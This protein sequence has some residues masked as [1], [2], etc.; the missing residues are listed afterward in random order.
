MAVLFVVTGIAQGGP[1][2]SQ[3]LWEVLQF[4]CGLSPPCLKPR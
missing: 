1:V 4:L 2:R 3:N